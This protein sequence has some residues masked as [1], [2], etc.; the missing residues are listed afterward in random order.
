MNANET[1]QGGARFGKVAVL[2][3][4]RSAEREISLISGTAVLEALRRGGCDAHPFDPGERPLAEFIA[5]G[6]DRVFIVL[7]GRF[8]EDG[9]VQGT[10]QWLGLPYTGSGVMASALAMDK[11]R[12]KLLWQAAGIPTPASV[13]LEP[14]FDPAAVVAQLGLPLMVKPV[15][16]GSSIGMSKVESVV[17]L[18][19]AFERAHGYDAMVLAEQFIDGP[20]LTASILGDEPLPLIRIE[21][22]GGLY[23]YQ[24]KYF[25]DATRYHCPAGLP[26]HHE[27]R[28]RA[29][30]LK[31]FK[32]IGCAGWGRVDLMLDRQGSPYLLEVNTAP[33]MT[34][35]S[36]VPMAARAAGIDFDRLVLR[37]LEL[38]HAA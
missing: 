16:E 25:S 34:G 28:L 26:D 2:L 33:G 36:L 29:L 4:G 6:F 17:G 32:V 15:N 20:E 10:L 1:T 31:A 12:T 27:A 11:W 7:H 14:G 5:E 24:A 38:A 21:A 9:T 3:G 13:L 19:P 8:G 30:A 18:V 35:H 22:E 23:D 37:I